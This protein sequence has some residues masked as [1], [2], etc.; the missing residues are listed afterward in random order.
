MNVQNGIAVEQV[1]GV[2][3]ED[4]ADQGFVVEGAVFGDGRQF[5]EQP[6][7]QLAV[8]FDVRLF[9]RQVGDGLLDP[10]HHLFLFVGFAGAI[11][12]TAV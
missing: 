11:L 8:F 4:L 9:R 7:N 6:D 5:V 2:A 10:T 3:G 1:V 12:S